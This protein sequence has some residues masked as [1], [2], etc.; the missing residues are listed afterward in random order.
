MSFSVE[1]FIEAP[2]L[3]SLMMLKSSDLFEQ[4]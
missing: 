4:L 3:S 2:T 1:S